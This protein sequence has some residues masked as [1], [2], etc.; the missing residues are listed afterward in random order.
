MS[1]Y[2]RFGP[3]TA[4]V[5]HLLGLIGSLTPEQVQKMSAT[6]QARDRDRWRS[7]VKAAKRVAGYNGREC[8]LRRA[9]DEVADLAP[10]GVSDALVGAALALVVHDV[11]SPVP[12]RALLHPVECGLGHDF[13]EGR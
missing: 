8:V 7:A 4:E 1:S 13:E 2:G 11:L 9:R 3:N 10:W 6:F 12:T 5:E